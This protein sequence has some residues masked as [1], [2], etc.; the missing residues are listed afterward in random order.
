M[1][2]NDDSGTIQLDRRTV[3]KG[4][5][6]TGVLAGVGGAGFLAMSGSVAADHSTNLSINGKS[7]T[8][9]T[10]D[11]TY[12]AFDSG[13]YTEVLWKDYGTPIEYVEETKH[14]TVR[15]VSGE[16]NLEETTY[17]DVMDTN[18]VAADEAGHDGQYRLDWDTVITMAEREGFDPEYD[19]DPF[20]SP[21]NH[22]P[23]DASIFDVSDDNEGGTRQFRVT[24]EV[25]YD[26]LDADEN[27]VDT[28]RD[29]EAFAFVVENKEGQSDVGGEADT[30]AE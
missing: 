29:D 10:G 26:L 20:G 4:A 23:F 3:L 1:E 6:T 13:G 17:E 19:G 5:G 21:P 25:V 30:T 24:V 7:V 27:V 14:V 9:A 28:A 16:G 2:D 8:N 12:L 15:Q 11:V 22:D 18:V